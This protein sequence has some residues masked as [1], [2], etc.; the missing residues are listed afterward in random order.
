MRRCCPSEHPSIADRHRTTTPSV[1]C[2]PN[3]C[4]HEMGCVCMVSGDRDPGD[5]SL[6]TLR[7]EGID[8]GRWESPSNLLLIS[9][10]KGGTNYGVTIIYPLAVRSVPHVAISITNKIKMSIFHSSSLFSSQYLQ[11]P[12]TDTLRLRKYALLPDREV[13]LVRWLLLLRGPRRFVF[14]QPGLSRAGA[15]ESL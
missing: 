11:V 7:H 4:T 2:D 15:S 10:L 1:G 6:Q 12:S 14:C 3:E 8:Q 5:R 13:R 9:S